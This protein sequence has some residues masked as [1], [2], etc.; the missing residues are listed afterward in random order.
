M[1]KPEYEW[2]MHEIE[3][4]C[5]KLV[6]LDMYARFFPS[7]FPLNVSCP[8]IWQRRLGEFESMLAQL[9]MQFVCEDACDDYKS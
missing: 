6:Y 1:S 9:D 2:R 7:I 5:E 4:K 8:S 3:A